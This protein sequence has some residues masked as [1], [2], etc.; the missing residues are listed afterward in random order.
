MRM[1]LMPSISNRTKI[2]HRNELNATLSGLPLPAKRVLF[3]AL[4]SVE[5]GE[6]IG[7]DK[8]FSVNSNVYAEIADVDKT[9]AYKQLREGADILKNSFLS[10]NK[11]DVLLLAEHLN[12]PE[13]FKSNPREYL[14][15][16]ITKIC[17]YSKETSTVDIVFSDA[18]QPYISELVGKNNKYTTQSLT[19]AVRL[20][21]QYSSALYQLVRKKY[22]NNKH[23]N[24]FT[25]TINE[26]K[27][28]LSC[29]DIVNGEI[30]YKYE[31]YKVF[32]REVLDKAI[33]E[34]LNKTEIKKLD[35]SVASREGKK[36]SKLE[37]SYV[38]QE[39]NDQ[40]KAEQEEFLVDFS[41][42]K[43]NVKDNGKQVISNREANKLLESLCA[44]GKSLTF[45]VKYIEHTFY[46]E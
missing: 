36:I 32:K 13:E 21:G 33:K 18:V 31:M 28:E 8:I 11:D 30:N 19:S 45:A 43:A 29:F 6:K 10:L 14:D 25:L 9:V 1:K 40:P 12:I 46:V 24:C 2:R 37:F 34:I 4:A 39:T 41:Q 3:L 17:G 38:I 5:P 23:I 15:L 42:R 26:L 7:N 44:E 22:S 20:S 16:N 27:D 35:F